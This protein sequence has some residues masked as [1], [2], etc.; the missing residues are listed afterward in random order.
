MKMPAHVLPH[1]EMVKRPVILQKAQA[2]GNKCSIVEGSLTVQKGYVIPLRMGKY[3]GHG[4]SRKT[5]PLYL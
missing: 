2:N 5:S 3:N 4:L 1:T